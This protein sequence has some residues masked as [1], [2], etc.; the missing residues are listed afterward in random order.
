MSDTDS[1]DYQGKL[2]D[3]LVLNLVLFL[4]SSFND[5]KRILEERTLLLL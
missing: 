2:L 4:S 1:H 3:T 5:L